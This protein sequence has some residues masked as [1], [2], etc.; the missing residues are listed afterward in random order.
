MAETGAAPR[1][2]A[3]RPPV[4]APGRPAQRV[5]WS[6]YASARDEAIRRLRGRVLEIGAGYGANFAHLSTGVEWI[7]LEPSA[8][9]SVAL[10]DN[11]RRHGHGAAPL[12]A[13]AEAI[14]LP[15]ASVDVV[16]ATTVLC[17]VR[18]QGR[19]LEEAG[20]V[21]VPGGRLLLAEHVA[22]PRGTGTRR[23]QRLARPITRLL[24]HGC[25]P[26][27]DTEGAVRGSL[28]EVERV[29]RFAVPVLGRLAMPFIV[30]EAVRPG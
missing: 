9:R 7:G 19:V 23:L 27:R 18:D 29:H 28:F 6:A 24:D 10:A 2:G 26:A 8:R 13:G 4:E 30:V 22:A 17:S 16:L 3:R 5:G 11:A 25:D 21:L 20:R 1:G 12:V 15:D 14:P